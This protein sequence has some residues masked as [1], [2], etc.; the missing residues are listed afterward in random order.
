M[1]ISP[2]GKGDGSLGVDGL[3]TSLTGGSRS[4]TFCPRTAWATSGRVSGALGLAETS[5]APSDS[6]GRTTGT[7]V[8]PASSSPIWSG[9]VWVRTGLGTGLVGGAETA[10]EAGFAATIASGGLGGLLEAFFADGAESVGQPM[11]AARS[12]TGAADGFGAG[13]WGAGPGN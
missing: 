13:S 3:M 8:C 7:S 6:L 10:G 11:G 1:G 4:T 12:T 9:T 2:S 5:L